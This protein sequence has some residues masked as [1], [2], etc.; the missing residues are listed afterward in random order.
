MCSEKTDN[1]TKKENMKRKKAK[2]STSENK[3]LKKTNMLASNK[4]VRFVEHFNQQMI[5]ATVNIAP[6]NF[7]IF[8]DTACCL[9][10]D[11]KLVGV[12]RVVLND[13]LTYGINVSC[14]HP[15]L[16][17]INAARSFFS[18]SNETFSK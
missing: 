16:Q 7:K 2:S 14:I 6:G 18:S 1:T 12:P 11:K 15:C 9:V 8:G 10:C 4:C 13:A 3:I 17:H 5:P